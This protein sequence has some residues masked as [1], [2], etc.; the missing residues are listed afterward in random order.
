M[1]NIKLHPLNILT[2]IK[3]CPRSYNQGIAI[4]A[5]H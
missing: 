1:Q 5:R 4:N 3:T 2:K